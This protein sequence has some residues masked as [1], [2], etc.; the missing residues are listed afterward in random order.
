M[1][2]IEASFRDKGDPCILMDFLL[3]L[4]IRPGEMTQQHGATPETPGTFSPY[5]DIHPKI[6]F[7]S[8]C[9]LCMFLVV[10]FQ[11]SY[12]LFYVCPRAM[13]AESLSRV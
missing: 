2:I 4:Q 10:Y 6:F 5:L 3:F 12:T 9:M 11:I 8:L 13:C 1:C 7:V